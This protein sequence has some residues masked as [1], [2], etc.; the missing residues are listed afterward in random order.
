MALGAHIGSFEV[1]LTVT[2]NALGALTN[3][4]GVCR[5]DPDGE[6][7]ESDEN[8]NDCPADVVNVDSNIRSMYLPMV[9]RDYAR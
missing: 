8:N 7:M 2:P 4:A 6:V 1:T 3:P 5:V 9:L